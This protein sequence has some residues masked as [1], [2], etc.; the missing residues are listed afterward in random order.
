MNR[1]AHLRRFITAVAGAVAFSGVIFVLLNIGLIA[2]A[3]WR[4]PYPGSMTG[5]WAFFTALPPTLV[6]ALVIFLILLARLKPRNEHRQDDA[7]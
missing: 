5:F 6:A 7:S 2:Y 1:A 4:Y 3:H